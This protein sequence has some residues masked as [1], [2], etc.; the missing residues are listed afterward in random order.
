L[1]GSETSVEQKPDDGVVAALGKIPSH[2]AMSTAV[3]TVRI[4]MSAT[5][6]IDRLGAELS[7]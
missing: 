4:G 5:S 3:P 2:A 1:G 7:S 6:V